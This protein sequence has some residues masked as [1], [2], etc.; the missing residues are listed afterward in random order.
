MVGL[1]EGDMGVEIVNT[2]R[3]SLLIEGFELAELVE[4]VVFFPQ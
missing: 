4:E 3:V 2:G 1:G